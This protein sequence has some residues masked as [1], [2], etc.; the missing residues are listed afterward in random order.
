MEK[1]TLTFVRRDEKVSPRTNKPYT[2]LSIKT[3]EYGEKYLSGFG[4]KDNSRWKEGDTVE[5]LVKKIQKDGKEYL[6]FETPKKEDKTAEA[7]TRIE[8]ALLTIKFG[9]EK[10]IENQKPKIDRSDIP[11]PMPEDFP[12]GVGN[13]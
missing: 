7:L 4:S 6:N 5:I 12:E 13:N 1:V 8:N 10:I 3:N 2:S 9:I 11:F